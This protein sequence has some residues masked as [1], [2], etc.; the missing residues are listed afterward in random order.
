MTRRLLLDA[1]SLVYRAYFALP[2]SIK[3]PHGRPVNAARDYVAAMREI[4][5][6]VRDARVDSTTG[7]RLD[8]RALRLLAEEHGLGGSADRLRAALDGQG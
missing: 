8:G 2:T 5:P 1:P 7:D 6:L 3:G 4:V